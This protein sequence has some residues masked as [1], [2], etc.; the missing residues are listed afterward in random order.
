MEPKVKE[1][2]VQMVKYFHETTVD[3]S[4]KFLNNL[5]RHYYV[6]PTSY[7]ELISTFK[8]L[9]KD[10]REEVLGLK[11]R[12][13][14]GYECLITTEG[15]VSQMQKYLEELKPQLIETSKLTDEKMI[16]VSG[17]KAEADKI[18]A[19]VSVEEAEAQKIAAQVSAIKE[20]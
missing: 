1:G 17:E 20:D 15:E 13:E 8:K 14:N 16:K 10:K 11:E 3:S 12:Y 18:A 6:T 5:K 9:L 7:L 2:C 4:V 19:K